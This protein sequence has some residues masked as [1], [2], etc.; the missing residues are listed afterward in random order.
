MKNPASLLAR[1]CAALA[2]LLLTLT[3]L[4]AADLYWDA[5]GGTTGTGG[6][7]TW[8]TANTWR[9]GSSTGTL[10]SWVD[11]NNAILG[12]TAGTVTISTAVNANQV[13]ATIGTGA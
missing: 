12:G 6:N 10:Q 13:K 11:G 8:S 7:G 4:V 1:C 9:N 5:N 3:N 2:A